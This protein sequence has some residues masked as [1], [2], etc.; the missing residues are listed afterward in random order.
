MVKVSDKNMDNNQA[1]QARGVV[2]KIGQMGHYQAGPMLRIPVYRFLTLDC[3]KGNPS[4]AVEF[5]GP[6][7]VSEDAEGAY[8]DVSNL[9]EGDIVVHPGLLYRKCVMTDGLMAA[10]MKALQT[11]Q[12]KDIITADAPDE[13]AIDLGFQN[14][15]KE[16][17]TDK[18]HAKRSTLH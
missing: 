17:I 15:S 7:P 10:H 6:A 5:S 8:L 18:D 11:Y 9:R 2:A 4:L 3:G 1:Y 12:P 14:F 13:P 16:K